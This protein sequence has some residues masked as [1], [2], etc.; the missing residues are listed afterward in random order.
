V[1]TSI[2]QAP[3]RY[4]QLIGWANSLAN[5]NH[6]QSMVSTINAAGAYNHLF[7]SRIACAQ[8]M[9]NRQKNI[10]VQMWDQQTIKLM[11]GEQAE[12][13]IW[14]NGLCGCV[15]LALITKCK[16]GTFQVTMSHFPPTS[17][18]QQKT[19]LRRAIAN[20]NGLCEGEVEKKELIVL[21]PGEDVKNA[22]GKWNFEANKEYESYIEELS[23]IAGVSA[24]V[25]PYDLMRM[26]G[27]KKF[28]PDFQVTISSNGIVW[29]SFGDD[30]IR[31]K[32]CL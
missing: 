21:V 14:K 27:E 8:T 30:H 25:S 6:W 23:V 5:N 4:Q 24:T 32:A 10:E 3:S 11:P 19:G 15:A 13:K 2:Q 20:C 7:Q 17:L 9:E 28:D 31:H 22:Q 26:A 16:D 18:N 29:I 1:Q 12:K